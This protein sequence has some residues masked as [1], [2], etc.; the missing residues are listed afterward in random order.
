M[1]HYTEILQ[2]Y[3]KKHPDLKFPQLTQIIADK[4]NTRSPDLNNISLQVTFF[5]FRKYAF[6][7]I[8]YISFSIAYSFPKNVCFY[9]T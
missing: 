7:V 1:L 4:H 8:L 6:H 3:K 2:K 5:K 9:I